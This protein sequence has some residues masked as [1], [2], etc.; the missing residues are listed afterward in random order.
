MKNLFFILLA[1]GLL[2]ATA[3][4]YVAEPDRAKSIQWK[5]YPQ[6][7]HDFWMLLN[8]LWL[9]LKGVSQERFVQESGTAVHTKVRH[10]A[11]ARR[12]ISISEMKFLGENEQK[13]SPTVTVAASEKDALVFDPENLTDGKQQTYCVVSGNITDIKRRFRTVTATLKVQSEK[14]IKK[15]TIAHGAGTSARIGKTGFG[16]TAVKTE[17]TDGLLRCELEKPSTAFEFTVE[18]VPEKY[19]ALPYKE[20]LAQRLKKYPF[21]LEPPVRFAFQDLL[22]LHAENMDRESFE[23]IEKEYAQTFI[24]YRL[25][26]WDS[27]FLQTVTRPASGRFQDLKEFIDVPCDREGMVKNFKTF[28][29]YHREL[30]GDKIF[31]LSGMVNFEH[32]GLDFG[33][34]VSGLEITS[35]H[36]D[37][38]H[39]NNYIFLRGSARQFDKPMMMYFAYFLRNYTSSSL[40]R[41]Q[42]T[43]G[44]DFGAPPSLA[45][46]NFYIAYYMGATYLDFESQPFGQVKKNPDDTHS[47]TANGRA[48]KDIFEWSRNP[49][50]Q[51]GASYA[52]I[53]LLADRK[54]GYDAWNR[55]I[56][57]H[58]NGSWY[59]I[60]PIG[61]GDLL[62]EYV[63]QA[64]NPH[65]GYGKYEE[66]GFIGNLRNSSLGDIFDLYIANPYSSGEV[67]LEQIEKYPVAF[68]VDDITYTQKLANTF[69]QYVFNGGTLILTAGQTAPYAND[70][71]FLGGCPKNSFVHA[72]ELKIQQF[73]LNKDAQ[74]LMRASDGTP[75]IV[76]NKYGKGHVILITSPFMK[77]MNDR[78]KM[79]PQ[80]LT[81]LENI[82][83]ELLPVRIEGDCEY[84]FNVMP[85]GTWK[86]ILINNRGVIKPP[87]V[88]FEKH[89]PAYTSEVKIT[90]PI[91]TSAVELR[92]NAELKTE[93]RNGKLV[94]S[95]KI[96]PAEIMVVDISGIRRSGAEKIS[97]NKAD[98]VKDFAD[99]PYTP[100][101]P[102][103]GYKFTPS[104]KLFDKAPEIIGNWTAKDGFTDT[105]GGHNMKLI[106]LVSENG[107][108][109]FDGKSRKLAETTFNVNYSLPEGTWTIWAK[110]VPQKD[111]PA[112]AK[113]GYQRGGVIYTKNLM[114]EYRSGNWAV[115]TVEGV[116]ISTIIGPKAPPEWTH[117]AI[118]WKN[119][120]IR[121]YVNGNEAGTP[122][123]PLKLIN[124]IG[125]DTFYRRISLI[126]GMLNPEWP[127]YF[128]FAGELGDFTFLSK[129]L[130]QKEISELAMKKR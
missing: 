27:N 3:G 80:M 82:Q 51:R 83:A 34:T 114:L 105:V 53:L 65:G 7:G 127:T 91:G 4:N 78:F 102:N 23:K 122:T 55:Y 69:K 59:N 43:S 35:E 100:S 31:G 124:S 94:F 93:S 60:F 81:M 112:M 98:P 8:P 79:P 118:T 2:G 44:L 97:R 5:T 120:F 16:K 41:A 88:S 130:S 125:V 89:D 62:L 25:A 74:V 50:G 90:A 85:D 108:M 116:C 57:P 9:E 71:E 30:F 64:V 128:A 12:V 110:P 111:F 68:L 63:M 14:P 99:K 84:L 66:P 38:Q 75:L 129:A 77:K 39:R 42:K 119:G 15:F 115:L 36:I 13:I 40:N 106:G 104:E 123:G 52:P 21:Y 58:W 18:S 24:G 19:V 46:R 32:H 109:K 11:E 95:I 10:N 92:N 20:D 26:E 61:D 29:D 73:T 37:H 67:R 17:N 72:D 56:E 47:L 117:L 101:L 107:M 126:L 76:K 49:K 6:A 87:W 54:H 121:F 96:L 103:D 1:G 113:A 70:P 33:G 86:I 28:W 48:L 45:L 22:G